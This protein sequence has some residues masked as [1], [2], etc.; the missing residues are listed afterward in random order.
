MNAEKIKKN[1]KSGKRIRETCF[2]LRLKNEIK[3]RHFQKYSTQVVLLGAEVFGITINREPL[4]N[5][6][7]L[8]KQE[9]PNGETWICNYARE[10]WV[11]SPGLHM[12]VKWSC[13]CQRK[14]ATESAPLGDNVGK[15]FCLDETRKDSPGLMST[16][17]L[18]F[19]VLTRHIPSL[20]VMFVSWNSPFLASIDLY[21]KPSKSQMAS[22]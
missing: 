4:T 21:W 12:T 15:W 22:W 11:S 18:S 9:A 17:P 5:H 3:L 7:W 19:S 14:W 8:C 16:W 2:A 6:A 10:K 1:K 20:H 13:W